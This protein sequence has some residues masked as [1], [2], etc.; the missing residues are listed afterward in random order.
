L[1]DEHVKAE[2][3]KPPNEPL[4]HCHTSD[5]TLFLLTAAEELEARPNNE[6]Y[7]FLPV[8]SNGQPVLQSSARRVEYAAQYCHLFYNLRKKLCFVTHRM[9]IAWAEYLDHRPVR[10]LADTLQIEVILP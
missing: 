1:F 8:L 6:V 10:K 4:V 2:A 3:S 7:D 5:T 9:G